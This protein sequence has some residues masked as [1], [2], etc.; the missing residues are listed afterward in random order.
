MISVISREL[1]SWY[2]SLDAQKNEPK[3]W[4]ALYT[5]VPFYVKQIIN[6]FLLGET[7]GKLDIVKAYI[8]V[9]YSLT[10]EKHWDF[11]KKHAAAT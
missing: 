9:K 4:P 6:S 11:K 10:K 3:N 7:Y 8:W 1:L 5:K 2:T